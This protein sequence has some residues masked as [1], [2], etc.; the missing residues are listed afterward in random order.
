MGDDRYSYHPSDILGGAST[1]IQPALEERLVDL[2]KQLL[3]NESRVL[4]RRGIIVG[5]M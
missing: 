3:K 4:S 2:R 5:S 1:I